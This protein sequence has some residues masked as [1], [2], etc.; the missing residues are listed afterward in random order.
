MGKDLNEGNFG[1]KYLMVDKFSKMTY[2]KDQKKLLESNLYIGPEGVFTII[3]FKCTPEV[4]I[5]KKN[6]SKLVSCLL[7]AE[8]KY[9]NKFLI[10][11]YEICPFGFISFFKM[12]AITSKKFEHR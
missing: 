6:K 8:K 10:K 5:T 1:K 7:L 2:I 12:N 4:A 9:N 3:S 11:N